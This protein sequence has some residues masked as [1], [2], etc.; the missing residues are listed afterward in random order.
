MTGRWSPTQ[1]G[2][3]SRRPAREQRVRLARIDAKIL[4]ERDTDRIDDAVV[5]FAKTTI[6]EGQQSVRDAGLPLGESAD[7][8]P[9]QVAHEEVEEKFFVVSEVLNHQV[10]GLWNCN[11]Q[12]IEE[13]VA[14]DHA[15]Q[16]ASALGDT[17]AHRLDR[18]DRG[19]TGRIS[20][21]YLRQIR[22]A[23]AHAICGMSGPSRGRLA[24]DLD[25]AG[26]RGHWPNDGSIKAARTMA[27]VMARTS[28][29]TV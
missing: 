6:Y 3:Q 17:L 28:A 20:A 19:K 22:L 25:G 9:Q 24:P 29:R 14:S 4:D 26:Q 11:L 1:F 21:R 10:V 18:P 16:H 23:A 12:L 15:A 7:R 27:P 13:V 5:T 2:A 8:Q